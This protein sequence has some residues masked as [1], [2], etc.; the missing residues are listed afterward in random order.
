MAVPV[1]VDK[2][3]ISILAIAGTYAAPT[4]IYIYAN[5]ASRAEMASLIGYKD[6]T[7]AL[8][9][10]GFTTFLKSLTGSYDAC[11]LGAADIEEDTDAN[12]PHLGRI[13][14]YLTPAATA[15]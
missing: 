13:R 9:D 8:V 12:S 2:Q 5:G 3:T 1:F 15:T 7:G 10:G 6:K 11:D 4:A 14:L